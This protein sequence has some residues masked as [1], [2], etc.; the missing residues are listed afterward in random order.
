VPRIGIVYNG[1]A[2]GT[3]LHWALLTLTR[4]IPVIS[5]AGSHGNSHNFGATV[6]ARY[7]HLATNASKLARLDPKKLPGLFRYHPKILANE[8]IA[9]NLNALLDHV[10]YLIV[11]Y[12]SKQS[13]LLNVNNYYYKIW[14]TLE[15]SIGTHGMNQLRKCYGI[16]DDT[17]FDQIS[18]DVVRRYLSLVSF[19]NWEDQVEW[20]FPDQYSHP[21]CKYVFIDD[22]LYNFNSTLHSIQDFTQINFVKSVDCIS[23]LH[24]NNMLQQKYLGQD[25]L[26]NKILDS[27]H[28]DQNFSWNPIDLTLITEAWIQWQLRKQKIELHWNGLVSFPTSVSDLKSKFT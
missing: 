18:I 10:D 9:S 25:T 13:Y 26:A 7:L 3:Y 11:M 17:P 21:R 2:Y 23:S 15:Q 28:S 6:P 20:F 22:L 5:P 24:E 19:P 12:P 4:D 16:S 1:G 14:P 8:S 27:I